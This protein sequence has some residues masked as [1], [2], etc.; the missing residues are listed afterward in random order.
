MSPTSAQSA[1]EFRELC[2]LL[3]VIFDGGRRSAAVRVL[4]FVGTIDKHGNL[5]AKSDEAVEGL[6]MVDGWAFAFERGL[7]FMLLQGD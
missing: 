5:G 2:D 7:R 4:Q 3:P 1:D 6:A